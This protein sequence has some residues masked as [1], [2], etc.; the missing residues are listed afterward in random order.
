MDGVVGMRVA[1]VK[2]LNTVE[3]IERFFEKYGVKPDWE[4]PY[5]SNMMAL[6]NKYSVW[7]IAMHN[8]FRINRPL[9]KQLLKEL[10]CL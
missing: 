6:L 10:S 7:F 4:F 8:L 3:Y 2:R 5:V 9:H 1:D